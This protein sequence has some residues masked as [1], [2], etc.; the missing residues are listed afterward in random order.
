[1]GSR[2]RSDRDVSE[3]FARLYQAVDT[4][5]L[6]VRAIDL[7]DRVDGK[8][9]QS[10]WFEI[11]KRE[12][13]YRQAQAYASRLNADGYDVFFMPNPVRRGGQEDADVLAG[14]AFW[15]DIDNLS[16][17]EAERKLEEVL[18]FPVPIDAAVFSGNGLH[19]YSF[20]KEP[21]DPAGGEWSIYLRGLRAF[22]KQFG[23]DKQCVNPGR[24]LRF[25]L[26]YSHKRG[27]QTL[28][29]MAET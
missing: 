29:W 1:M 6:E 8:R 26:S 25:P 2:F 16:E 10:D 23:G 7:A 19:I 24:V 14:I 22:A 21:R 11:G 12:R 28:L 4:G 20:L 17:E 18:S 15:A 13:A 3:F 9:S 27:V 5:W